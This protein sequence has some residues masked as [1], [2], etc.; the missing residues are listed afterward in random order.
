MSAYAAVA[1]SSLTPP[2]LLFDSASGLGLR[3]VRW[4]RTNACLKA[5]RNLADHML[6]YCACGHA[7]TT[8]SVGG[9]ARRF[10]QIPRSVSFV[11]AGRLVQWNFEA[12]REVVHVHIYIPR[13][14]LPEPAPSPG[15]PDTSCLIDLR[16]PWLDGFFSLLI[17]EH[18]ASVRAGR[19]GE[20]SFLDDTG[21]LLVGHLASLLDT[22]ADRQALPKARKGVS[23]LRPFILRR[24][25]AY[26]DD[27]LDIEI[28]LQRLAQVASMSPGHLVRAFK[29]A[30][31]L[32]PYQYV[33]EQRLER[34][35]ELLRD[36]ADAVSDIARGC[37]FSSLSHFSAIFRVHRGL[38]PTE[39]RQRH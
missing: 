14:M 7:M 32:T 30:T 19:G 17:A 20:S 21:K 11:P 23:A 29:Q 25:A 27:N 2:D 31:G 4:R 22:P 16:D 13:D 34:A 24:I 28:D 38:T 39:Y 1:D 12:A 15:A 8:I 18:A 37:G 10:H 5:P 33:L 6:S 35:C 36:S 26:V 3:A 9:V